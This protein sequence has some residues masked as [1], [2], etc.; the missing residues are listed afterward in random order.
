MG[1]AVG[2]YRATRHEA[3]S[4]ESRALTFTARTSW[5]GFRTGTLNEL[6]LAARYRPN[7]RFSI[8]VNNRWSRF[9]L[10]E[11]NFVVLLAGA[12]FSYAFSCFLDATTFVQVNK[13]DREAASVN[14]RIRYT[15]RPDSDPYFIYN[16]R[17]R[18]ASLAAENPEQ[19]REG[20][21]AVKFTY[22][23]SL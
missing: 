14:F 10:P 13:A 20:R 17:T 19:L 15:F 4:P 23:F 16:V 7:P 18:F 8:S 12:Q 1:I 11:R 21:L 3:G 22:S 6:L 2:T 9:R 5:G